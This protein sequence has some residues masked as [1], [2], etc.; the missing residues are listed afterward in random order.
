MEIWG[1]FTTTFASQLNIDLILCKGHEYCKSE[2]EIDA[3]FKGKYIVLL[4]N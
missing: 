4:Y 3:F 1:E 2:E